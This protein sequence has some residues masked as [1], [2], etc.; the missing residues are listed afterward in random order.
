[1]LLQRPLNGNP[2]IADLPLEAFQPFPLHG[3][4]QKPRGNF[5]G[6]LQV[7]IQVPPAYLLFLPRT[8]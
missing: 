1:M 6:Q 4:E 5:C 8:A 2:Q 7:I 3:T